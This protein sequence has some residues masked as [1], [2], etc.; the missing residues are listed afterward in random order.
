M[1]RIDTNT[2]DI[3]TAGNSHGVMKRGFY[4]YSSPGY[5]SGTFAHFKTNVIGSF[6]M[7]MIEVKGTHYGASQ[8]VH[9]RWVFYSYFTGALYNTYFHNIG[10][11]TGLSS[12]GVYLSSD[13][14][15]VIWCEL[16][17]NAGD[18]N[19]TFNAVHPC[20]TGARFPIAITSHTN[21][22]SS[23]SQY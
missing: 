13:N 12:G 8:M 21:S 11:T 1:A 23:A 15:V 10:G 6:I 7:S 18:C 3:L 2:F 14:Y 5:S 9:S 4:E 19:F 16:T 17:S 20:P 22:T